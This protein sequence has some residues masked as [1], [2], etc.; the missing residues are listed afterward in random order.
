MAYSGF[1]RMSAPERPGFEHYLRLAPLV[2]EDLLQAR[3]LTQRQ[4]PAGWSPRHRVPTDL[5]GDVVD[6]D[7]FFAV[8]NGVGQ[9]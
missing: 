7:N 6:V 5:V 8:F 2:A 4:T 1:C 9:G 3:R